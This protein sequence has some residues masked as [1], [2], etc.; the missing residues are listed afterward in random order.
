LQ[1]TVVELAAQV[2]RLHHASRLARVFTVGSGGDVSARYADRMAARRHAAAR[3][4]ADTAGEARP[5]G[6]R[7]LP[8]GGARLR[9]VPTWQSEQ[10]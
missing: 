2:D 8:S 3:A 9:R 6:L 1:D 10:D 7:R 4:G 5:S